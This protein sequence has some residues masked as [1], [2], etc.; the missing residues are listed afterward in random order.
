MW[1][2]SFIE[3][4][5]LNSEK[6]ESYRTETIFP[7]FFQHAGLGCLCCSGRRY[8][9]AST[10]TNGHDA[11]SSNSEPERLLGTNGCREGDDIADDIVDDIADDMFN[12]LLEKKRG[13]VERGIFFFSTLH[14]K[15][16]EECPTLALPERVRRLCF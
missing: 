7:R 6:S 2:G 5:C 15:K 12:D 10:L 8:T 11:T 1:W 16:T 13:P 3:C 9:C 4:R 14:D